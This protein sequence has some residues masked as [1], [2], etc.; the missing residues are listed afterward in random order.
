MYQPKN[1]NIKNY[2]FSNAQKQLENQIK[3]HTETISVENP[4][5]EIFHNDKNQICING[6]IS[7]MFK[8][9]FPESFNYN[10]KT[11]SLELVNNI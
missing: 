2:S 4:E 10:S 6:D 5:L 9:S 3:A 7:K 1:K 8:T 11:K